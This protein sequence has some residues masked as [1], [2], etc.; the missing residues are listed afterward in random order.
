MAKTSAADRLAGYER[1][2][3][4]AG[5]RR[6]PT[7]DHRVGERDPP[8]HALHHRRLPVQRGPTR[9]ARPY[10]QWT[11]KVDGKTVTRRLTAREA[12]LYQEWIGN[13]RP[14]P[15]FTSQDAYRRRKSHQNS[16][17]G[18]RQQ[19]RRRFNCKLRGR[20]KGAEADGAAGTQKLKPRRARTPG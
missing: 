5:P 3:R 4:G 15:S 2:Y 14:R 18:R 16:V 7:S 8:L 13:D 11:A 20:G 10:W 17:E 19:V 12:A 6:S 1:Q 9:A